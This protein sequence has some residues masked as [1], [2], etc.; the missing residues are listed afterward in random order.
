MNGPAHSGVEWGKIFGLL[1]QSRRLIQH[2][3]AVFACNSKEAELLRNKHPGKRVELQ[4]HGIAMGPDGRVYVGEAGR[5]W[6]TPVADAVV[7]EVVIDGLP[8]QLMAWFVARCLLLSASPLCGT[9][10]YATSSVC[11]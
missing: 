2:A 4:P 6:R 10:G 11:I 5:I 9:R 3:D 8:D 1:L 7:P